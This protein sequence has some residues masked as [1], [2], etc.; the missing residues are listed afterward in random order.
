MRCPTT[1]SPKSSLVDDLLVLMF[2]SVLWLQ[3]VESQPW[4]VEKRMKDEQ[5]KAK[6]KFRGK[7]ITNDGNF[8]EF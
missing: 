3:V 4:H 6:K 7:K 5:N 1:N 8:K 2:I